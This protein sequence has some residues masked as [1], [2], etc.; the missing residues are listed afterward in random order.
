MNR[1]TISRPLSSNQVVL[2]LYTMSSSSSLAI[3]LRDLSQNL[4]NHP[5]FSSKR[6]LILT[7][8]TTALSFPLL[9]IT[10][11]DYQK[12]LQLGRAGP[13]HNIF[14]YLISR[15]LQPLKA[16]RFDTSFTSN[17]RILKK[18][19][20]VGKRAFL[21]DEDVP[22]RKGVRPEVCKWILPQRQLDQKAGGQISTE[23]GTQSNSLSST[24]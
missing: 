4:L 13:P 9:Y 10:W 19:G 14:G 3:K 21:K 8:L 22:E 15:L 6:N 17:A 20:P 16:S 5:L 12:W 7:V 11:I 1:L 23:V 24:R 18:I 2:Y